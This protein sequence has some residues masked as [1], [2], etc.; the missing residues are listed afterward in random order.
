MSRR[1]QQ[2][3]RS[4]PRVCGDVSRRQRAVGQGPQL[5]PRMR[6]CFPHFLKS[7]L[8][9]LAFPAYAGM[10]PYRHSGSKSAGG[11]P[12]VCGD[13]S[14]HL[15]SARRFPELSPRMRGCFL[16]DFLGVTP[17]QAFPAYAGMFLVREKDRHVAHRFPRVCGDVSERCGLF[18]EVR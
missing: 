13:V 14:E 2:I 7:F 10:F 3:Q 9:A 12:R 16:A 11:F 4:F 18:D 8:T 6:G 1:I 17:G 15:S 5:S